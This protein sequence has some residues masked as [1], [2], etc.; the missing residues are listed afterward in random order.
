MTRFLFFSFYLQWKLGIEIYK[1]T[2]S[3]EI[4]E[5]KTDNW[6]ITENLI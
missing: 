1:I 5:I 6:E 2:E 4:S 3:W